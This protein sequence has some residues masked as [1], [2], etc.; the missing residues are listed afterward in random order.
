VFFL[1]KCVFFLEILEGFGRV[2]SSFLYVINHR[3]VSLEGLFISHVY[4]TYLYDMTTKGINLTDAG[5]GCDSS[6]ELMNADE[7]DET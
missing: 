6:H 3:N 7:V 2:M 4:I 1:L 5:K